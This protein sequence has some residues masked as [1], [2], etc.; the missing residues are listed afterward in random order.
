MSFHNIDTFPFQN[1][2][3]HPKLMVFR[4][5]Q[6]HLNMNMIDE[7]YVMLMIYFKLHQEFFFLFLFGQSYIF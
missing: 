7:I 6:I 2:I 5:E 4:S 1:C 3:C